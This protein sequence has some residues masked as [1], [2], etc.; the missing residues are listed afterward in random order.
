MPARTLKLLWPAVDCDCVNASMRHNECARTT[1]SC[2]CTSS[3][4][5]IIIL[6]FNLQNSFF[7]SSFTVFWKCE[8]ARSDR[9]L[10]N[11]LIPETCS[12]AIRYLNS[13]DERK[14]YPTIQYSMMYWN[15]L[16]SCR[17]TLYALISF[18]LFLSLA[19]SSFLFH[20]NAIIAV[21]CQVH[22]WKLQLIRC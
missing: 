22:Q 4:S 9:N 20:F 13:R 8:T 5:S 1:H 17:R 21:T 19:F 7:L 16:Q 14:W 18:H 10:W 11:H 2:E 12:S 15:M 3:R 6:I